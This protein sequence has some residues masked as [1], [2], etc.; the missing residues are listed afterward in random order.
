MMILY[1]FEDGLTHFVHAVRLNK[2][3]FEHTFCPQIW[4]VYRCSALLMQRSQFIHSIA[5]EGLNYSSQ[6][7]NYGRSTLLK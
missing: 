2:K 4:Q 7:E 6:R 1:N 3:H 5:R